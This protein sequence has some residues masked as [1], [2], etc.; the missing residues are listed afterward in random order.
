MREVLDPVAL[1]PSF[2]DVYSG[3]GVDIVDLDINRRD[4]GERLMKAR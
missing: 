4:L 2:K 1:V 3:G